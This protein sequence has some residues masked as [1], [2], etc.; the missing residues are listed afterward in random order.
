MLKYQLLHPEILAALGAAGHGAQVLIAD[1]NYPFA[2]RS[3][4]AARRVFL[5]LA[6]GMLTVTDVLEVL[7]GAIPIEAA[8]V[9]VPHAGAEPP[10]FAEFRALLPDIEL[11]QFGRFPFYD[12]ARS[13]DV[14]L[15]IA[16]GEQ[17]VYANIMLTIGVVPPS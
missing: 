1:G 8:H 2:T 12:A 10:I 11:Q 17:R 7:V 5:N 13:P 4:P 14:A 9:M 3:N 6:P 16:T 15:V